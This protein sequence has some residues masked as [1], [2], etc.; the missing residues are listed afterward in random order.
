MMK[1]CL[2]AATA[3]TMM[4]GIALAQ[5]LSLTT[6]APGSSVPDPPLGSTTSERSTQRAF[7][8]NGV[9]GQFWSSVAVQFP[10]QSDDVPKT[11]E[12]GHP[13]VDTASR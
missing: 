4:T 5:S 6:V 2:A 10:T 1:L 12:F 8:G 9:V 13:V 11:V 3:L 7:P